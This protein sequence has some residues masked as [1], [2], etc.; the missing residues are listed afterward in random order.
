MKL[1]QEEILTLLE[2]VTGRLV[3]LFNKSLKTKKL[4]RRLNVDVSHVLL[5]SLRNPD[6]EVTLTNMERTF[7]LLLVPSKEVELKQ[8]LRAGA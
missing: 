1:S 4:E 5:H 3:E 8:K 7:L 6:V 2:L